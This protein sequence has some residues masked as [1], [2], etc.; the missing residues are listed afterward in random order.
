MT[1][2]NE[3]SGVDAGS[4]LS[5]HIHRLRPG[6]THGERFGISTRIGL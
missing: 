1:W 4:A 2:S 5:L 3:R 6:A